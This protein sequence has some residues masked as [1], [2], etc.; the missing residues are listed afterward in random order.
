MAELN[1]AD[2]STSAKKPIRLIIADDTEDIR[3]L[4]RLSL[5]IGGK[6]EICGEAA[7]G[8]EAVALADQLKPDAILLDLAMPVMD[9]L[10]AAPEITRRSPGT[11]IVMLSGFSR[12]RLEAA[13]EQAGAAAYIE[14]GAK[15]QQIADV[16]MEVC[17][18]NDGG[19]PSSAGSD[20]SAP[21]E[22][23]AR[24][25]EFPERSPP[26]AVGDVEVLRRT[27]AEVVGKALDL[28]SAFGSFADVVKAAIPFDIAGFSIHEADGN[29]RVVASSG[30][31][32]DRM[33]TGTVLPVEGRAQDAL[34]RQGA[35]TMPDTNSD[36]A[37][38]DSI[39]AEIGIRSYTAVPLIVA[40][41]VHAVIGL[42]SM[43][44]DAFTENDQAVLE[45]LARE[46][47]AAFNVLL[48]LDGE[49]RAAE[50]LQRLSERQIEWNRIVRHDLRSPLTVIGG[51]AETLRSAWDAFD[52]TK[53][54][55]ML[56]MIVRNASDMTAMLAG[57]EEADS[58]DGPAPEAKPFDLGELVTSTVAVMGE[59]EGRPCVASLPDGQVEAVGEESKQRRVLTNLLENAFKFSPSSEP[60]EVSVV[61]RNGSYDVS[62]RDHGVGISGDDIPK[63]FRKF[64][65]LHQPAG[66]QVRG[67]GLGLFICKS[68]VESQGGRIWVES[69][70]GEGATF[71]YSVPAV[72]AETVSDPEPPPSH[73]TSPDPLYSAGQ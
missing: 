25:Y 27:V 18:H 24:V 42:G 14:K 13:A 45:V 47:A 72:S 50:E 55:E 35:M 70:P 16:L 61:R 36:E 1:R 67:T 8:A 43:R 64:S 15:P 12:D 54:G 19:P 73:D 65:R 41:E 23:T 68:L 20:E 32:A 4:L 34:E 11:K 10:Q 69:D 57:L 5:S 51:I 3:M 60:V 30:G 52:D 6:F 58:L 2:G 9:G 29:Y 21:S 53:R 40:G 66:M 33:P 26:G 71:S 46:A 38:T 39:L 48:I 49:R 63:L 17:G 56:D 28:T 37:G 22:S 62:V 44:P 59:T 7:D 31:E